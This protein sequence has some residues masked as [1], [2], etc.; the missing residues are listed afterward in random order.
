M[1]V[2]FF[3]CTHHYSIFTPCTELPHP[4]LAVSQTNLCARRDNPGTSS[5]AGLPSEQLFRDVLMQIHGALARSPVGGDSPTVVE[6]VFFTGVEEVL[7]CHQCSQTTS[8]GTKEA[9]VR[10]NLPPR[11]CLSGLAF[12]ALR[13][14]HPIDVESFPWCVCVCFHSCSLRASQRCC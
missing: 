10:A 8:L 14:R 6:E 12:S 11:P 4:S 13:P 5:L 7:H 2:F 1:C 3:S 9:V